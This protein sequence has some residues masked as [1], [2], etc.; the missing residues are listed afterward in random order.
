MQEVYLGNFAEAITNASESIHMLEAYSENDPLTLGFSLRV[1]GTAYQ[2]NGNYNLAL[3]MQG[4]SASLY[5]RLGDLVHLHWCKCEK[6]ETLC[7][8]KQFEGASVLLGEVIKFAENT[9]D[10]PLA[11][12]GYVDYADLNLEQGE[13]IAAETN[14]N[15]AKQAFETYNALVDKIKLNTTLATFFHKKKDY[16]HCQECIEDTISLLS[17]IESEYPLLII[18]DMYGNLQQ[19][20]GNLTQAQIWYQKSISL[21]ERINA[22]VALA[23]THQHLGSLY[24]SLGEISRAQESY[25]CALQIRQEL[26]HYWIADEIQQSI[27]NL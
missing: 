25:L 26:E 18:Y 2:G 24:K 11:F 10:F 3:R 6:A 1:L 23:K 15:M 13:L 21:S 5:G 19:D 12:W 9:N 4:E 7:A 16:Q 22:R 27:D 8:L 17:E 20:I 14:I